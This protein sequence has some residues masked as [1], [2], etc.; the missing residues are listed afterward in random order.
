MKAKRIIKSGLALLLSMQLALMSCIT[1][2]AAPEWPSDTGVLADIGIAVDAD[3]GAVLFGQGIHELTPPASITKLLT[4]L[5][6]VENSSMDDM[7]TFSYDAV[8]NVESGSGNKKNI[9]EGDKLSVKDCLYLL[10]L[11][12]SNQAANALAEHVAGSRDAFADMMNEKVKELGCTDGTH[13]ANPSGLNDDTQVVSAYDMAIIAQAAFNNSD[14]LEISSTKS[15]KLAPTQNNPSGATCANEHRLIITDDETSELYCP[16]AKAGKTG[17]TSLAGNTLVTYGEKDGRRVI[18]VVLKG[19]PSPN[20]FLDGKTLLQF[21]FEN[22]QN[23]SI[24][25]NETKYV[26]GEETVSI[27]GADFQPDEL[28]LESGAVITL[29]KDAAFSDASMELV[30]ELPEQHPERAV[31]LL[32]YTYN[33]RKIG[34]AYLLAKEGS[35][36]ASSE[37]TGGA[38]PEEKP[39]GKTDASDQKGGEEGSI[40]LPPLSLPVIGICLLVFAVL[41]LSAYTLYTKKKE[42][43]ELRRRHERR[44]QRLKEENYTE[45]EFYELLGREKERLA[46]KRSQKRSSGSRPKKAEKKARSPKQMKTEGESPDESL[47]NLDDLFFE[48]LD[49][50]EENKNNFDI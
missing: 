13:F 44:M 45:E 17:Y 6:V 33:D 15:Y 37:E 38:A 3:S 50:S 43:E 14:V 42:A 7:V 19:Q 48:D 28:D 21:G 24:P 1:A 39:D 20:Y 30:T 4:A 49:S 25:D 31:A 5:V 10:L 47:E 16:E 11:Q 40:A 9:A 29:P 18:S 2:L 35:L 41:L 34:Q 32:Q 36:P 27:N 8:N 22:F 12:S 26:T 46:G 23:V